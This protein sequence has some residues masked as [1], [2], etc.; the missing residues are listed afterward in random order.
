[1]ICAHCGYQHPFRRLPLFVISGPSGAGK[2]TACLALAPEMD[3]CV[4]IE[5]DNLWGHVHAT[6]E[7]DYR[8]Y[9]N[10]WLGLAVAIG[11]AGRPVAIFGTGLP[12][13]IEGC[14]QRYLL[15]AVHYLALVS[16]MQYWSSGCAI[17]RRGATVRRNSLPKCSDLTAGSKLM[18]KR[19]YLQ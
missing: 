6:L 12:N 11:Q 16:M 5:G 10:V 14:A 18:P 17:D 4:C 3:A 9:W 2:T 15:G 1:M 8:S 7:D 13:T 19:P